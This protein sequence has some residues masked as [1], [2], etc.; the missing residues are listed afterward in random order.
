MQL[1]HIFMAAIFMTTWT[2]VGASANISDSLIYCTMAPFTSTSYTMSPSTMTITAST[3]VSNNATS[4]GP[5]PSP[6]AIPFFRNC[7]PCYCEGETWDDLG[8]WDE[9]NRALQDSRI[10]RVTSIPHGY[11]VG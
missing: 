10:V 11:H 3:T 2:L 5:G 8:S 4:T 6:T 9:I 7:K 1:L